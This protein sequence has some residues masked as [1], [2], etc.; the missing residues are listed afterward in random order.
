MFLTAYLVA[1]AQKLELIILTK[2]QF[3][4]VWGSHS[5]LREQSLGSV[6]QE[7]GSCLASQSSRT[8]P[9]NRWCERC[10][11]QITLMFRVLVLSPQ[12]VFPT[13][14]VQSKPGKE[15]DEEERDNDYGSILLKCL[16]GVPAL[17]RNE[18]PHSPEWVARKPVKVYVF[19]YCGRNEL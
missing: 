2:D 4:F 15:R 9:G 16:R 12:Y 17:P 10:H 7:G 14:N 18:W 8:S 6:R 19:G 3:S 5:L 1:I 13:N 11:T